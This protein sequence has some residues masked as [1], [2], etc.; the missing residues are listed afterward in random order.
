MAQ[1]K[2]ENEILRAANTAIQRP[3]KQEEFMPECIVSTVDESG[4]RRR[5]GEI[6]VDA[7]FISPDELE[8]AV[9]E[10][11]SD[12]RRRLG[13][14]LV[15]KGAVSEQVLAHILAAQLELPYLVFSEDTV[16]P[17]APPLIPLKLA[18]RHVCISRARY[19][20]RAGGGNGQPLGS[21]GH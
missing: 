13:A 14:I 8:A 18:K 12:P 6:L 3:S 16:M 17:D 10:Q 15:H 5:L 20:G 11:S 4:H 2:Q 1:L 19:P 7:G 21:G 9:T